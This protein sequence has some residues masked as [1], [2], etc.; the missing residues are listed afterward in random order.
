MKTGRSEVA[1]PAAENES[2]EAAVHVGPH[3]LSLFKLGQE[4]IE[5]GSNIY[6]C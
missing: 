3:S 5:V 1:V 4:A 2:A 6:L